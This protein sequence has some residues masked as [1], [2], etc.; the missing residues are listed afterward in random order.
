M[1]LKPERRAEMPM[2]RWLHLMVGVQSMSISRPKGRMSRQRRYSWA[3]LLRNVA[4]QGLDGAEG[5]GCR[6]PFEP[7]N[8][9][10]KWRLLICSQAPALM[11]SALCESC[12]YLLRF[13][14]VDIVTFF[15]AEKM[16]KR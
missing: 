14:Y 10:P 3:N 15:T 8:R 2:L 11:P 5:A 9:V 7:Y 16:F 6:V 4:N 13:H 12:H 1:K